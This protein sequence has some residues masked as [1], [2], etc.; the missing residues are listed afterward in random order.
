MKQQVYDLALLHMLNDYLYIQYTQTA[1][2][3][4]QVCPGCPNIRAYTNK[5]LNSLVGGR[6]IYFM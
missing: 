6:S 5:S 1:A 4:A 2:S 3:W